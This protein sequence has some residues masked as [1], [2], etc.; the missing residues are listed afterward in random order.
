MNPKREV[1]GEKNFKPFHF[2]L[3]TDH[4]LNHE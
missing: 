2:S 1:L 4:G 3:F